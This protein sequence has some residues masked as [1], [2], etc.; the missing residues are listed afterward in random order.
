VLGAILE[1]VAAPLTKADLDLIAR[2]FA[3]RLP[4]EC[5][6][7]LSRRHSPAPIHAQQKTHPAE[8]GPALKNLD[9]AGYGRF[10]IELA[11]LDA[12]YS[13]YSRDGA[14]RLEAVA[15]RYRVNI[16]KITEL[17]GA[18]FAARRK[19]RDERKQSRANRKTTSPKA[20]PKRQ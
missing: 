12:T 4:Q 1:K 11:L 14:E 18:E 10:L 8:T 6:T 3:S 9:E 19:K 2:E 5:R 16:P 7:I 13:T 17:V 15:K 20:V